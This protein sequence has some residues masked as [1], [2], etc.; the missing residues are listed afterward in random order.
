MVARSEG[1]RCKST[2]LNEVQPCVS[3]RLDMR[4][5]GPRCIV[6]ILKFHKFTPATLP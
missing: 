6:E 2:G 1:A 3:D 4:A 5:E